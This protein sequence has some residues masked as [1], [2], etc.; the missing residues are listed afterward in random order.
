MLFNFLYILKSL[1][2]IFLV[3]LMVAFYTVFERKIFAYKGPNIVGPFG[4]LQAI[5]D[6]LK[7]L[8]KKT[9]YPQ[10]ANILTI[11]LK[12]TLGFL[13]SYI[14][15]Y[16]ITN[17]N[18]VSSFVFKQPVTPGL[19]L[20]MFY[21][22]I[23]ICIWFSFND[24]LN[25]IDFTLV[26]IKHHQ[27]VIAL[28]LAFTFLIYGACIAITCNYKFFLPYVVFERQPNSLFNILLFLQSLNIGI[29]LLLTIF[30]INVFKR[31]GK[32]SI[33]FFM[34]F[35]I[36]YILYS[37][38]ASIFGVG[39]K[40]DI[41]YFDHNLMKL[42]LLDFYIQLL[43]LFC[44]SWGI[45]I[46]FYFLLENLSLK[47][48]E[49]ENRISGF[50]LIPVIK[51]SYDSVGLRLVHTKIEVI[52]RIA[53]QSASHPLFVAIVSAFVTVGLT[54]FS[55]YIDNEKENHEIWSLKKDLYSLNKKHE[56]LVSSNKHKEFFFSENPVNLFKKVVTV[57]DCTKDP[58]LPELKIFENLQWNSKTQEFDI[59]PSKVLVSNPGVSLDYSTVN[60][61]LEVSTTSKEVV[62]YKW[63]Y[64]DT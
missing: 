3:L 57:G 13:T 61:V 54:T 31:T 10:S 11:L 45:G 62:P 37:F 39:F 49:I 26:F 52:R 55:K 56:E 15:Y 63:D 8:V 41:E 21:I 20:F 16:Y 1:V 30:Y 23:I 59:K 40:Q 50:L 36:S 22:L 47:K 48:K 12:L 19:I 4:L 33:L 27:I 46:R 42:N 32:D 35:I 44:G 64:F 58:R 9:I 60:E 5:A 29:S 6:A 25:R 24:V 34:I 18:N 51:N 38:S 53:E 14:I 17:F 28:I 7:L 2:I 43:V